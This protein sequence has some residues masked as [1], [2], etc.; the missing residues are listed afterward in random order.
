MPVVGL[1]LSHSRI[2]YQRLQKKAREAGTKKGDPGRE[3]PWEESFH[4]N[5]EKGI[6]VKSL[7]TKTQ[8]RKVEGKGDEGSNLQR[9]NVKK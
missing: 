9:K 6:N 1:G 3:I 2:P 4:K 5:K 7:K 8:P